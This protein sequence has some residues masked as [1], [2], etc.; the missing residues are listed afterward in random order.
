MVVEKQTKHHQEDKCK[1]ESIAFLKLELKQVYRNY[2]K[3]L[4]LCPDYRVVHLQL[5]MITDPTDPSGLTPDSLV[6]TYDTYADWSRLDGRVGVCVMAFKIQ[7][8][9]FKDRHR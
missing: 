9:L 4:L 1:Y 5:L 8:N 3:D 7:N 2:L 6:V